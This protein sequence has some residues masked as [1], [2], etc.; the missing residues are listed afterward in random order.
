M[1]I[2]KAGKIALLVAAS[3]A[4]VATLIND[5]KIKIGNRIEEGKNNN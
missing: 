4:L 2:K 3:T 5:K 1:K